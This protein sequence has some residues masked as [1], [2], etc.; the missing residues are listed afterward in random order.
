MLEKIEFFMNKDEYDIKLK[1][2]KN[3]Y[4]LHFNTGKNRL[5]ILY[6][7]SAAL[8][9]QNWNIIELN[10]DTREDGVVEDSFL[11]EPIEEKLSYFQEHTL[12]SAI[13]KLLNSD[14][15][16]MSYISKYPNKWK[17]IHDSK[18][19]ET[20]KVAVSELSYNRYS[21]V[22]E[23][24]DRPGLIFEITQILYRFFFDIIH[25]ESVTEKDRAFDKILVIRD[26]D[27]RSKDD[28]N[29]LKVA[30]EKIIN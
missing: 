6:K 15:S 5:G 2:E 21:L 8:Y 16:A 22:I 18:R 29:I 17:K 14:I 1:K 23:T 28:A 11:I 19:L 30:I 13:K 4:R 10:A 12:L 24:E 20:G 7:I 9:V 26:P 3:R 25:M 27:K